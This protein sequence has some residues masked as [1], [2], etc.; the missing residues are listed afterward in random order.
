MAFMFGGAAVLERS[1]AYPVRILES[2]QREE[3]SGFPI[4]PTIAS[5]LL[6]MGNPGKYDLSS[7]RYL[8]NTG[9]VLP[10]DH[11]RRMQRIFH[12]A[13]IYSMYGLTE[14]KRVHILSSL[15]L[16]SGRVL[17]E[18]R[19]PTAGHPLSAKMDLN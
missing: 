8:T 16:S 7:I 9:S 15:N 12:R 4:V 14:C 13:K 5:L 18:N 6:K 2:I 10:V 3:I 17:S 19:S 11:I 1:F